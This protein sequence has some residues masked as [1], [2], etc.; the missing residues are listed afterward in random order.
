MQGSISSK[1]FYTL[2]RQP[3]FPGS[4]LSLSPAL[5]LISAYFQ[6]TAGDYFKKKDHVINYNNKPKLPT[7]VQTA[8]GQRICDEMS[9]RKYLEMTNIYHTHFWNTA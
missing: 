6:L 3:T 4:A 8:A 9:L 5:G 7:G 2:A 1:A